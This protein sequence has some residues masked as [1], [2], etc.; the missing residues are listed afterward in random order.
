MS[1]FVL[2]NI[3]K[4]SD[5]NVIKFEMKKPKLIRITTVPM[6]LEKLLEGQLEYMQKHFDVTAIS[7]DKE[8]LEELGKKIITRHIISK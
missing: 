4:C 2:K 6:S 3:C 5:K 1:A 7:A 8:K